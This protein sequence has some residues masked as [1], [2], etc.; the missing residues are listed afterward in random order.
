MANITG[1]FTN[2]QATVSTVANEN[3]STIS[4]QSKNVINGVIVNYMNIT[5]RP[6]SG[7]LYPRISK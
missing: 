3:V 5:N 2:Y 1:I 7:Q 6:T 4:I